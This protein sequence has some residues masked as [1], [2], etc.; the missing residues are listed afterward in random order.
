MGCAKSLLAVALVSTS[1]LAAL[2][3]ITGG[4]YDYVVIGAGMYYC[5][6]VKS[7]YARMHLTGALLQELLVQPLLLELQRTL[8]SL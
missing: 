7:R 1:A 4:S 8:A 2:I 3:P 5:P 6:F